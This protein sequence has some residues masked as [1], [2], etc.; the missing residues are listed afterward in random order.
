MG[1]RLV[2]LGA[3]GHCESVLDS[4]LR[5]EQFKQIV[6]TDP[7][8]PA[9]T[10]IMGCNV[11]GT[12]KVLHA[13]YEE[14]FRQAFVTVGSIQ[15]NTT[16]KR[17]AQM[18]IN[19]GFTF[20]VITDPSAVISHFAKIDAGTF[21]GKN[22]VVNA[23]TII[24]KHCIINTGA[25]LEHDCSIGAFSHISVGAI[26]CGTV[27]VKEDVFIGSGSTVIQNVNIGKNAIIGAHSTV[28]GDVGDNQKAY[29][30]IPATE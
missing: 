19:I 6:I 1:N 26:L 7:V 9:G 20:P 12:D 25:I 22:A 23:G 14:G 3:G 24:G 21:I 8:T 11:V 10:K 28:L 15:N 17:L 5:T 4:A 27:T 18:A 2:L 16:R 13:L 30:I 29:G